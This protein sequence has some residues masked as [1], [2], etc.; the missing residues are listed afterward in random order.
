[1]I[2]P[3][4]FSAGGNLAVLVE[5]H[6]DPINGTVGQSVLLP[7]SYRFDGAPLFPLSIKWTFNNSQDALISCAVQNCSLG[8]GGAPSCCSA[9]CFPHPTYRSRTKLFPEN[10]S[11]LLRDGQLGDSGVYTVT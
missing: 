8:A 9:K 11:L 4:L 5:I 3:F 2:C 7:I 1:L 6:R 10:G